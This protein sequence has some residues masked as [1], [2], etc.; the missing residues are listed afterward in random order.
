MAGDVATEEI[1][2]ILLT[3]YTTQEILK[4]IEENDGPEGLDLSGKDLSG[5]DLGREAIEAELE[6]FREKSPGET[7]VWHST[8]TGGINLTD[9]NLKGANLIIAKLRWADLG[10]ANLQEARL[11]GA[12]LH[13]ANL[14]C[15]DLREANLAGA[16]LRGVVLRYSHLEKVD[17]SGVQSLEGAYFYNVF[18]D[19]TRM[20]RKQLGE[21]IGEDLEARY[22]WAKEA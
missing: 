6:K 10:G 21:K 9:V 15:A 1:E 8:K 7:P 4:L 18:L 11:D 3:D 17:L 13:W 16:N 12:E 20:R 2:E 14:E 5:I 22:Y 19:S